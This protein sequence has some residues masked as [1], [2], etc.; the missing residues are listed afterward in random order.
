M[1]GPRTFRRINPNYPMSPVK[2]P[3]YPTSGAANVE[4][5]SENEKE[6]EDKDCEGGDDYEDVEINSPNNMVKLK[7]SVVA[8]AV[9]ERLGR[10][11]KEAAY[12]ALMGR[13]S[14]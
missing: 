4:D 7:A 3:S 8:T 9:S 13:S 14:L 6:D 2:E 5:D 12:W 1:V 11:L 10:S